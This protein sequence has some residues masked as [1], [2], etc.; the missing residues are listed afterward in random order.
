MSP[1]TRKVT[2]IWKL[3][4]CNSS[5]SVCVAMVLRSPKIVKIFPA[6]WFCT[7]YCGFVQ[8]EYVTLFILVQ[9]DKD[10]DFQVACVFC[11]IVWF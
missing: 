4:D 7:Q 8:H 10:S 1:G 2:D 5:L 6:D 11:L 9:E 3:T